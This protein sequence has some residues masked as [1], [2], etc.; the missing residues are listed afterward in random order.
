MAAAPP[1]GRV[2]VVKLGWFQKNDALRPGWTN[3]YPN[4]YDDSKGRGATGLV[5][6]QLSPM[7]LGP[8][9]HGQPGL[10]DAK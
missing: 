3:V 9:R 6:K 2:K 10:P 7:S 8:V 1:P 5:M 4:F